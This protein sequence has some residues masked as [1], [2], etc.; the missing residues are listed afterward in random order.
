MDFPVRDVQK[1][2]SNRPLLRMMSQ[3]FRVTSF[4]EA[5]LP[6]SFTQINLANRKFQLALCE[7]QKNNRSAVVITSINIDAMLSGFVNQSR[8]GY[9]IFNTNDQLIY[10]NENYARIFGLTHQEALGLSFEEIIRHAHAINQGV[11]IDDN[12]I[13]RFVELTR[14]KRFSSEYR[15]FEV[16]LV[17]GRWLLFSE[18]LDDQGNMLCQAKDLTK[19]KILQQ[20]LESSLETMHSLALTDE[21]TQLPNRRSF[22]STIEKLLVKASRHRLNFSFALLDI[23]RFK[24]V[25]DCYGHQAGDKALRV[26]AQIMTEE[27]RQYDLIGR[28]GGEEFGILIDQADRAT[29]AKVAER[30]K[31]RIES[32]LFEVDNQRFQLTVSIGVSTATPQVSFSDLY[33]KADK[34]LYEAK[35]L[36][37]NQV[38]FFDQLVSGRC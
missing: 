3:S 23:D 2:S 37:R 28:I 13:E 38:V 26:T 12:D 35:H 21:L 29:A 7:R 9:A 5:H 30:I 32:H 4:I 18:Q 20:S 16:D 24:E 17:D 1:K 36:G 27:L 25:N 6:K 22:I 33:L 34:A 8:D 15:L 31:C 10:C 11:R 14:V 19:Q